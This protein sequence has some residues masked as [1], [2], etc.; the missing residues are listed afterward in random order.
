MF[1]V[2]RRGG[3]R[4]AGTSGASSRRRRPRPSEQE[5]DNEDLDFGFLV[6]FSCCFPKHFFDWV[7]NNDMMYRT[8]GWTG[9][10]MLLPL[11][12]D[13]PAFGGICVML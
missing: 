9:L 3:S 4:G 5:E 12:G 11:T 8:F 1:S 10:L 13:F 2:Q 7:V 6:V